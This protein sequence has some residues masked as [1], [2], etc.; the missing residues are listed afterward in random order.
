MDLVEQSVEPFA[1]SLDGRQSAR[2]VEQA[3]RAQAPVCLRT[4]LTTIP[5][6]LT[7]RILDAA[8]DS[9]IIQ[10]DQSPEV[11]PL[12][13]A[14]C[15]ASLDFHGSEYWFA[16]NVLSGLMVEGELRLEL[17]RPHVLQTRQRRR[18]VR[19]NLAQSAVVYISQ[20]GQIGPS[21][22]EG[23]LLNLSLNGLACRVSR[24]DAD[25]YPV[26]EQVALSFTVGAAE[27]QIA[28]EAKL[29]SK[30]RASDEASIIVG[31]EFTQLDQ[32]PE[33]V[34]RLRRALTPYL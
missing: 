13:S 33:Q 15:D 8:G 1:I 20:A 23:E 32:R 3:I 2:L 10:I 16:T 27:D 34:E 17:S 21:A 18:F 22:I 19:T 25:R 24:R 12:Q 9:L 29:R 14:C 4:K 6:R 5:E 7:G 11:G 28:L 30:T 31:L 26:E